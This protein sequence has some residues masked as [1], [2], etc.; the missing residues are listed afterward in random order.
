RI[1]NGKV[2]DAEADAMAT[3][4][5]FEADAA[6]EASASEESAYALAHYESIMSER[7]KMGKGAKLT[8]VHYGYN[9]HQLDDDSMAEIDNIIALMKQYQSLQIGL[10]GH[11][12]SFGGNAY[13]LKLSQKRAA[14]VKAYMVA[15][16]INPSR[17]QVRAK[18]ESDLIV[19]CHYEQNCTR[20]RQSINRRTELVILNVNESEIS[21]L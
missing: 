3:N 17:L 7:L 6:E 20:Y 13:N 18:G 4:E 10:V 11:T 5:V 8:K 15:R 14:F 1:A 2:L 21:G 16:G 9:Q 19:D 12:D